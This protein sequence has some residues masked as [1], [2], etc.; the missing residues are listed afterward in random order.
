MVSITYRRW[1]SMAVYWIVVADPLRNKIYSTQASDRHKNKKMN[2]IIIT[3]ILFGLGFL[4]P[5]IKA[6]GPPIFTD[7]PI[8]LGLEGKGIRTFGRYIKK[9]NVKVYM[10]PIAVPFN[11]TA[12]WQIGTIIPFASISPNGVD[13]RFGLADL[14]IFTKYQLIQR[15]GKGKTFRSLIKVMESFPTGNTDKSP[16]LGAGIY[17]TSIGL[18]NGYV[19]TRYG[20]YT[21]FAYNIAF[22]G[23]PDNLIY[24]V[25][26]GVPLLPQKYPPKQ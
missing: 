3:I 10:H 25:A 21:E 26:L 7:T 24:N 1:W 20:I 15:D 13:G 18:V 16:P 19:T 4:L 11:V 8:M 23:R 5:E 14:K 6:Q 17:Q 9:E 12:K 22:D 2:K